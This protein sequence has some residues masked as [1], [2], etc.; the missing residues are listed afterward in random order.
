MSGPYPSAADA[1]RDG[2]F[3]H[4]IVPGFE[5]F[6]GTSKAGTRA[7]GELL[8]GELNCLSCHH[9]NA[10]QESLVLRKQAPI[11]DGLG[12]RVT[13]SYLR[14]FLSAPQKTKPGST[15][16]DLFAGVAEQEKRGKVEELVHFLAATGSEQRQRPDRKQ[17][18][19]G[20]DLYG[21]VGCVV[22]HGT[23][24]QQGKQDKL[25]STSVPLADLG[26]KYTLSGLTSFLENPH[27][28][29]PSG[30]MPGLLNA[31]EARAVATF[32]MQGVSY[33]APPANMKYAYYEGGWDQL[34]DF[35][36]LK[37]RASGTVAGFDL[38][39]ALREGEMALTFEGYLKITRAGAY[40]FHLTSDDGSRLLI[41][42]K[43]VV[44]NDGV[45][46][47]TTQ[48][49][50]VT[51]ETGMHK[52]FVAVF[53]AGGPVELTLDIEGAGLGRQPLSSLV[54]LTPTGN[55]QTITQAETPDD[56]ITVNPALAAK[57][58]IQ[59]TSMGCA[60]CHQLHEGT[61]VI[62]S[63]LKA[64]AL[65]A[66]KG[67][68]GCLA[69]TP[70]PGLPH[71]SLTEAQQS[72]LSAALSAMNTRQQKLGPKENIVR[73]MTAFNCYACHQRDK[74]GGVED[75]L[76]KYFTTNQPEMGEEGRLPPTLDGVGGKLTP[77]W[78]R[79]ILAEGAQERPYM[80]TRMPRFGEQN[81]GYLV[82]AFAALDKIAP[83]AR[84]EFKEA[85]K[86]VKAIARHMVGG[87]AFGCVKCHTFA[88]RKAEG[89]Q[90]ID[91][92]SMTQRLKHDWFHHYLLD[93]QK[94][95]PLTRM[96]SAWPMG[97]STLPDLLE[98]D[99]AKQ[100]EAIWLYLS[101]SNKAALPVGFG[102]H[103]I[104]LVPDKE[105]IIY[106]NFIEGAGT[107][108]IAVGYPEKA[109][110]AFDANVMRLAMI[111][112][113]AFIDASRHWTDRGDGFQAP[114]GDNVL[115][116]PPGPTFALLAKETDPWPSGNAKE[117]GYQFHGYRLTPDQRPTFLYSYNG[118]R[119]ED[120]PNAVPG[121]S[122]S[123][124]RQLELTATQPIAN[125]WFRAAA[126]A[127]IEP[128]EKGWYVI[129]SEWR[130][131]IESSVE[132]R[133]RTSGGQKELLVPVHF[134]KDQRATI[135]QEYVW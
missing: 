67:N 121:K 21:R 107:R 92:T 63:S 68:G 28:V 116:L 93:P 1:P 82:D 32:L 3:S 83:I 7:G 27:K 135:V 55:P 16:P 87:F 125:L 33:A 52:L 111:W 128:A 101:D 76:N 126:G 41:D 120:F 78:F 61:Q 114:L 10:H 14:R 48:T 26:A 34:P 123:I 94:I 30:R 15:M 80:Y 130:V 86:K 70:A 25:F 90:A 31:K 106:R 129:N 12:G 102:K 60:S 42:G 115:N 65:F 57:G 85:P 50:K 39:V 89:I 38:T 117:L 44:N 133:I 99:V 46:A 104:P 8:L 110:L 6:F 56:T 18:K 71:Y 17:L 62:T 49:G 11:L 103:F 36:R 45:H 54:Y 53:N 59:F 22:C 77:A 20:R 64:P 4:A 113:G 84:P 5:R 131:R 81:T 2:S 73:T 66:L 98:G 29:R 108:A 109:S 134:G 88:G 75:S 9:A 132:P 69:P 122:P 100:I 40:Q 127:R 95:R 37:P 74:R 124:R 13:V 119:V 112:Q 43:Q 91:M 47:S 35:S 105:A 19:L 118:I 72:A 51:L 79:K 23:R 96:P 24:D 97:L 58:R